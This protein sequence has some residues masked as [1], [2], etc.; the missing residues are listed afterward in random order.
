MKNNL[1][2]SGLVFIVLLQLSGCSNGAADGCV[3]VAFGAIHLS[4]P[5]AQRIS[6]FGN[7][8][9]AFDSHIA[10]VDCPLGCD[11]LFVNVNVS[12]TRPTLEQNWTFLEPE[13]TGR[14]SG[15]YRVYIDQFDRTVPKPLREILVPSGVVRPQDEFYSCTPEGRVANPTCDIRVT[16]QIGLTAYFSIQRKAL[17]KAREAGNFVRQ[18]LDQFYDNHT[19]GICK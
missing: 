8:T 18:T 19:K 10:G 14:M 3:D 2:L 12:S 7:F 11:E 17:S 6:P 5:K 16:T 4:V 15:L 9:F 13:F 1:S